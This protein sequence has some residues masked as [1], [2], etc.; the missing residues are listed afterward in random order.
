M[1]RMLQVMESAR[2]LGIAEPVAC[3]IDRVR[4]VTES[5]AL[6]QPVARLMDGLAD[7]F[8]RLQA[9]P[10]YLGFAELFAR[11]GYADQIPAGRRLIEGF[12]ARGFRRFN[13]VVDAYNV[14]SARHGCGLGLH[15]AGK[16]R[17]AGIDCLQVFTARADD[18]IRPLFKDKPVHPKN[19]DLT[20]GRADAPRCLL[21]W[22]GKRDVDSDDFKVDDATT[23][24]LLVVTGNA[25]TGRAHNETICREVFELIAL[26]CPQA[27]MRLLLPA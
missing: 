4:V 11:M 26:T 20:Y 24:L 5:G 10:H 12:L 23:S 9:D 22:L 15:D 14:V 7:R 21:A 19:G 17:A 25:R 13:N 8:A 27:T 1:P 6:D 16:V 18:A 2:R 3:V